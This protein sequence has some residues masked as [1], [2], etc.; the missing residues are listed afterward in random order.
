MSVYIIE[1]TR[2]EMKQEALL[3]LR[4][5]GLEEE[6][7]ARFAETGLPELSRALGDH[8]YLDSPG[9][10]EKRQVDTFEENYDSLVYHGIDS[11]VA[12]TDMLNWLFVSPESSQ[13]EEERE[14]IRKNRLVYAYVIS[15]IEEGVGEI[16]VENRDGAL[17][18]VG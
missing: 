5:L 8:A 4:L 11:S 7:V 3:R 12:F 18:R 1:A 15:E 14:Y 16:Q 2:E 13:W 9:Q 10:V 17:L 6:A